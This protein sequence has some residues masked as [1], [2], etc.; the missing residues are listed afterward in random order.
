M[1][2]G[3]GQVTTDTD[4]LFFPRGSRIPGGVKIGVIFLQKMFLGTG[5]FPKSKNSKFLIFQNHQKK[6]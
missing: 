4:F 2:K 6:C 1:P 5:D 3:H